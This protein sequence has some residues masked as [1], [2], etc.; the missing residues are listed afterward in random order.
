MYY[1]YPP[2]IGMIIPKD[3]HR[4]NANVIKYWHEVL[5]EYNTVSDKGWRLGARCH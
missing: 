1:A 5:I 4:L 2:I 3:Q